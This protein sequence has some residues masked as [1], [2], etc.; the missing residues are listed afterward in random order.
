[1]FSDVLALWLNV[2]WW[3]HAGSESLWCKARSAAILE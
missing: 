2:L 1:M 3:S